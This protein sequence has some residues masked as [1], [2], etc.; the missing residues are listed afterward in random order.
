M[1]SRSSKKCWANVAAHLFLTFTAMTAGAGPLVL[2]KADDVT[3]IQ[4]A[5]AVMN[6]QLTE[7]GEISAKELL[8][9]K[10]ETFKMRATSTSSA[11]QKSEAFIQVTDQ[12][13]I[14][15]TNLNLRSTLQVK[16]TPDKGH[17]VKYQTLGGRKRNEP[18]LT[19]GDTTD[20]TSIKTLYGYYHIWCENNG[21]PTSDPDS[22]HAVLDPALTITIQLKQ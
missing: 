22:V 12:L 10:F 8:V 17:V 1:K 18:P 7:A 15:A 20:E 16:S 9:S 5:V 21:T 2:P 13:R 3:K 11:E 19:A 4:D 14:A 6:P